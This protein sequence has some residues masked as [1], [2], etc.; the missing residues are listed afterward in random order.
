[1]S[2]DGAKIQPRNCALRIFGW[3]FFRGEK[4][5]FC[6]CHGVTVSKLFSRVSKGPLYR[7]NKL[8]LYSEPF[9]GNPNWVW[10]FDTLTLWHFD[11][12]ST[13]HF[14]EKVE[15]FYRNPAIGWMIICS[16]FLNPGRGWIIPA[17]PWLLLNVLRGKPFN[18][19][20]GLRCKSTSICL[21]LI[22]VDSFCAF[23]LM[24]LQIIFY[25]FFSYN[26]FF[27]LFLWCE[28]R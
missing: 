27:F 3:L 25:Q 1:M 2:F 6:W 11:T 8:F 18:H 17:K 26:D 10:H 22:L 21:F 20:Q 28:N 12:R 5:F 15:W 4:K 13:L 9:S 19:I 14:P 24:R 7:N 23:F 16:L